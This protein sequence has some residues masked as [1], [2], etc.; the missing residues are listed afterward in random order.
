MTRPFTYFLCLLVITGCSINNN[1]YNIKGLSS[2]PTV[3]LP[4]LQGSIG[5]TDLFSQ[6][7]ST[8]VKVYPDGLIYLSY[9]QELESRDIRNLVVI[10]D[11]TTTH[12][13]G[14]PSGTFPPVPSDYNS[15]ITSS[16]V[17]LPISPEL[18][19]EIGF[20]SGVLNYDMSLAPQNPGFK[21]SVLM[22]IPE[23]LDSNGNFFNVEASGTGAISLVGYTFKSVV[24]N[25]FTLQLT[26]VI[27]QNSNT[28]T[29]PSGTNVKVDLS[30]TG[31]DFTYIK[32]FFGDQTVTPPIQTINLGAFGN[33]LINGTQVS[34]KQPI[35]NLTAINDYVVPLQVNFITLLAKK[36]SG[37]IPITI[38]PS[39]PVQ[40]NYPIVL[41][42]S[43]TTTVTVTNVPEV[44]N[45][46]PTQL[47]YQVSG[48][49]NAGLTGGTNYMADTS[50]L[51]VKMHI[52]IPLYGSASNILL[53]DTV[54]LNLSTIN[55]TLVDVATLQTS[56]TNQ[57]PLSASLQLY[58]LDKNNKV[59]DSLLSS[60]QNPIVK[61]S[62]VDTSGALQSA[63]VYDQNLDLDT[64]KI[65]KL[66]QASKMILVARM[67][68][69]GS[70]ST[71]TDVKFKSQYTLTAKI[72]ML[73]KLKLTTTF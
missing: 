69:S 12:F 35:I 45:F 6:Q 28:V 9:D 58:L 59:L 41:G 63:G 68:T 61:G 32:G 21:Y 3:A 38:T 1:D 70:S 49:I 47:A 71:S 54:T 50:Q 31:L 2:Q 60:S 20:K 8:Y 29:I 40:T 23:F 53:T 44:L 66:F 34:F 7:D 25:R 24:A 16:P 26:L 42:T 30:L 46:A 11:V 52:E 43:A 64:N 57:I 4:L 65:N 19:N 39:N 5:L 36:P 22:S 15:T 48:R 51:R 13:L 17:S 73:I 37:S 62:T 72:G 14:V 67:N 33:S 18:L 56:I 10:P 55:Q 27:K